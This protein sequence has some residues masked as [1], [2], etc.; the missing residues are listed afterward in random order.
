LSVKVSGDNYYG[1]PPFNSTAALS[2]NITAHNNNIDTGTNNDGRQNFVSMQ[3][4]LSYKL[5]NETM[6]PAMFSIVITAKNA[7][8]TVLGETFLSHTGTLVL[9][10]EP[11]TKQ[12]REVIGNKSQVTTFI[13]DKMLYSIGLRYPDENDTILVKDSS[14]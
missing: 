3:V 4:R 12:Q 7:N 13:P 11:D 14:V 10:M 2:N 6:K 9:K 8:Q 1:K 5:S